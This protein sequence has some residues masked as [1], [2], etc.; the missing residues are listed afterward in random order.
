MGYLLAERV[1]CCAYPSHGYRTNSRTL[2]GVYGDV[3]RNVV[4]GARGVVRCW[5]S[6]YSSAHG[7]ATSNSNFMPRAIGAAGVKISRR[8][9]G[10]YVRPPR[11]A[12]A[13]RRAFRLNRP[14]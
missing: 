2:H 4:D 5:L 7:A 3:E 9:S 1:G 6:N 10:V 14:V 13:C 8:T 12:S 11:L